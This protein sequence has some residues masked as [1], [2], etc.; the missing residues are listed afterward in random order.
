MGGKVAFIALSLEIA[1]CF[2]PEPA[3]GDFAAA[4][5]GMIGLLLSSSLMTF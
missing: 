2:Y 5:G 1:P 3:G 4:R